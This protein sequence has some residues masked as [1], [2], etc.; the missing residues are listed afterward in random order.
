[1]T[2]GTING[3]VSP[4]SG[5]LFTVGSL[6]IRAEAPVGFDITSDFHGGNTGFAIFPKPSN[7]SLFGD[8]QLFTI[9]LQTGA[10]TLF[11]PIYS[12]RR[13]EGLAISQPFIF[14]K[15]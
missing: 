2:Q 13:I 12:Q 8:S 1:V 4:N 6:R 10:A 9:D 5:Q 14:F 7:S 3:S 11:G 15:I